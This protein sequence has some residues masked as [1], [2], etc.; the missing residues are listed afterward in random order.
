MVLHYSDDL[1]I[2]KK[3]AKSQPRWN[4]WYT[5]VICSLKTSRLHSR[6]CYS[7]DLSFFLRC[8][9]LL[10][11]LIHRMRLRYCYFFLCL[12]VCLPMCLSLPAFLMRPTFSWPPSYLSLRILHLIVPTPCLLVHR[13]YPSCCHTEHLLSS[14]QYHHAVLLPQ[15]MD[16]L[17]Q[18]SF[19]QHL[20]PELCI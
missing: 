20:L 3:I 15:F 5:R 1:L 8:F 14:S 13:R 19:A 11:H 9:Q 18:S 4:V 2:I 12:L 10:V 7:I 16:T 6:L 17:Q